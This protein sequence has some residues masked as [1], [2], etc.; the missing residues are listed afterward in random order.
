MTDGHH[1]LRLIR[2]AI[3]PFDPLAC[4]RGV[5]LLLDRAIA[6]QSDAVER[7]LGANGGRAEDET[8]L[9]LVLAEVLGQLLCRL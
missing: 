8:G 2:H 6:V 9:D 1:R 5:E 7:L 3:E 4:A